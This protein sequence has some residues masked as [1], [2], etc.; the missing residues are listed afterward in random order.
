VGAVTAPV[1]GKL[2]PVEF[3]NG[4]G[5]EPE[6]TWPVGRP[7]PPVDPSAELELPAGYGGETETPV[8]VGPG[9][10]TVELPTG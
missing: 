10:V 3:D 9:P 4:Y 7:V 6:G 5:G 2:Q 1:V 8:P